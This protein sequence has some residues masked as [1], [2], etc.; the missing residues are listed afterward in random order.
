MNDNVRPFCINPR[1]SSN[2]NSLFDVKDGNVI[3]NSNFFNIKNTVQIGFYQDE[4]Q[5]CNPLGASKSKFKMVGIYMILLNLPPFLRSK[6]DNIKLLML[7][8]NKYVDKFG[9]EKILRNLISDLHVLENEGVNIVINSEIM[10]FTGGIVASTGD[11]LGNHSIG[12]YV[13]HF[14]SPATYI[15]QYCEVTLKEFRVNPFNI[16]PLRTIT[17]YDICAAQAIQSKT[18][19]KGVEIA[20]PLNKLKHFHVAGPGLAPCVA[21]D[22]FEGIVTFDV[23]LAIKYFIKKKWIHLGLLNYRLNSIRL[24]NEAAE[25]IP[26][27]KMNVKTK[28]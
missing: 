19:I 2:S 10:N 25:F 24:S 17:N 11:N 23:Y 7:V 14:S 22:V 21:H 4:F 26:H 15:C 5:L 13:E 12:G 18:S 27:I 3:K 20:S 8:N 1:K 6:T 16:K 9:W 28:N